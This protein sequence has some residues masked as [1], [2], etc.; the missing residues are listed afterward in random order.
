MPT[1]TEAVLKLRASGHRKSA[2]EL[3]RWRNKD[4]H[5]HGWDAWFLSRD[6]YP[7]LEA[8]VWPHGY[9]S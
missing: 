6:G 8:V 4:G 3:D 9:K 1:K 7:E 5:N 2:D